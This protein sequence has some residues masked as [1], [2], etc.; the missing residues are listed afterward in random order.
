MT[1]SMYLGFNEA[2]AKSRGKDGLHVGRLL[3]VPDASMRPRQKAGEKVLK[4]QQQCL[5]A[6]VR[7]NEAPAKSRGKARVLPGYLALFRPLLQ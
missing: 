2:P 3:V 5:L 6:I 4:T 1:P 7:F